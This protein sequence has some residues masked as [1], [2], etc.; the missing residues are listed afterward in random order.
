M[1]GIILVLNIIEIVFKCAKDTNCHDVFTKFEALGGYDKLDSLQSHPNETIY[2]KVVSLMNQF[3]GVPVSIP[4]G[5]FLIS[6]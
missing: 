6:K 5:T 4:T 2:N 3:L 1:D